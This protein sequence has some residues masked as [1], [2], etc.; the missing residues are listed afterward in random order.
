MM[1][2][3]KSILKVTAFYLLVNLLTTLVLPSIVHAS[4]Y[5]SQQSMDATPNPSEW[6]DL[7]TGDFHYDVP[8]LDVPG[9]DGSYRASLTYRSG[10]AADQE[11]SWVGLGWDFSPGA[12]DRAVNGFPDD[13]DGKEVVATDTWTGATTELY[14]YTV[15]IS[16]YFTSAD[17][18][19][20]DRVRTGS[21]QKISYS[22]VVL[23]GTNATG[24]K[25]YG[26]LN[27]KN[28]TAGTNITTGRAM[29]V[30]LFSDMRLRDFFYTPIIYQGNPEK[31]LGGAVPA[32]D[33]YKISGPGLS[34]HITPVVLENGSLFGSAQPNQDYSIFKSFTKTKQQFRFKNEPSNSFVVTP[35]N[36][37][38]V[39]DTHVL[40]FGTNNL[41]YSFR[42][43][44]DM[45]YNPTTMRL[46]GAKHI[47][48]FTNAEISASTAKNEGFINYPGEVNRGSISYTTYQQTPN[49]YTFNVT[50]Q[51]G[52]FSVTKEDGVTYHYALPAYRYG[53]WI[54]L[55]TTDKLTGRTNRLVKK[56]HAAAYTWLLT[57]V[58]GPDFV[59]KNNNGIADEEDA[60]SWTNY[61]YGRWTADRIQR[62]PYTGT[63]KAS[64]NADQYAAFYE[65]IYYLDAAYTRSHTALFLKEQRTDCRSANDRAA[66]GMGAYSQYDLDLKSVNLYR[67]E[68]ILT[69]SS[70]STNNFTRSIFNSIQELK[71]ISTQKSIKGNQYNRVIDFNDVYT[72]SGT[73]SHFTAHNLL[74][75]TALE[76]DYSLA[77][78]T[79]TSS[80]SGSGRL[81]L[82]SV[83]YYGRM[84]TR[85][86][87]SVDFEYELPT[88]KTYSA[89]ITH[90]PSDFGTTRDGR[91]DMGSNPN[92]FKEGD[93]LRMVIS[94]VTFHVTLVRG[95]VYAPYGSHVSLYD[96]HFLGNNIPG[97][98]K[99]NI[100]TLAYET[101]NPPYRRGDRDNWDYF[102]SDYKFTSADPGYNNVPVNIENADR[103]TTRISAQS[104]DVWSLRRIV[105]SGGATIDVEYESDAHSN[106]L[107]NY[108]ASKIRPKS[109]LNVSTVGYTK[110]NGTN[111]FSAP[112]DKFDYNS[113]A[114]NGLMEL[115]FK[116]W[117]DDEDQL[118]VNQVV[119]LQTLYT[120]TAFNGEANADIPHS[121][122][123]TGRFKISSV[124]KNSAGKHV[125]RGVFLTDA[126]SWKRYS[127]SSQWFAHNGS[128]IIYEPKQKYGGGLR[129]KKIMV[130]EST[131]GD[132]FETHYSYNNKATGFSSGVTASEPLN[133]G[134]VAAPNTAVGT[135]YVDI[136]SPYLPNSSTPNPYYQCYVCGNRFRFA[137]ES[138][139][140][141]NT[142]T[143]FHNVLSFGYYNPQIIYA[144]VTKKNYGN[145]IQSP[146]YDEYTFQTF[147]D[148]ML[149]KNYLYNSYTLN[150]SLGYYYTS[151]NSTIKIVEN[152]AKLGNLLY[153]N[154]RDL[155][156]DLLKEEEYEYTDGQSY[157]S[158]GQGLIE[159]VFHQNK[160]GT[161]GLGTVTVKSSLPSFLQKVYTRDHTKGTNQSVSFD[162]YDFYSGQPLRVST[163]DT[164]GNMVSKVNHPAYHLYSSTTGAGM[165]LRVVNNNNRNILTPNAAEYL[166]SSAG[167]SVE[168]PITITPIASATMSSLQKYR[169]VLNG[170]VKL[171]GRFVP[172]T[173]VSIYYGGT[174]S[175]IR[176]ITTIAPD[177]NSFEFLSGG[178]AL[179]GTGMIYMSTNGAPRSAS[180]QPWSNH[181][182]ERI[183]STTNAYYMNQDVTESSPVNYYQYA[184]VWKP[185][186]AYLWN[187]PHLDTE[188]S[189]K[190]TGTGAYQEF[191]W[192]VQL[193][194]GTQSHASWQKQAQPTLKDLYSNVLET[195]DV[196]GNYSAT[197]LAYN[198]N[199][200]MTLGSGYTFPNGIYNNNVLSAVK[201]SNA[202]SFSFT[203]FEDWY[204]TPTGLMQFAGEFMGTPYAQFKQTS[205]IKPHTGEYM[206]KLTAGQ[207]GPKF[208]ACHITTDVE[209]KLI[210]GKKY[211]A[212]VWVHKNS[213]PNAELKVEV[214]GNSATYI[215]NANVLK[216]SATV[217]SGDW[218]LMTLD[219][220]IPSNYVTINSGDRVSVYVSNPSGAID[221]YFD[222]LA[223]RPID[224]QM[225]SYVYD[226][227]TNWLTYKIDNDNFYTRF[228]YDNTGRVIAIYKETLQGE[229]KISSNEYN[230]SKP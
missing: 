105:T 53:E 172:N 174:S 201:N 156:G 130:R 166:Y 12:I 146:S 102:K 101:K 194:G 80:A 73:I 4:S 230:F 32:Y 68:D 213:D 140:V 39:A 15:P 13:Y 22:N 161:P 218:S 26:I 154:V 153:H 150:P 66:G 193:A 91:I 116:E 51:V 30:N 38:I 181:A 127:F 54:N 50:N 129:T 123:L 191:D 55:S 31:M 67:N 113:M 205:T 228:E 220:D 151:G 17:G 52:G 97:V 24:I 43:P 115:T 118:Y 29:D 143:G 209:G 135:D 23:P 72:T 10:I 121:G 202:V 57:T 221:S 208:V 207:I 56:D 77:P 74:K 25:Y 145:G 98:D 190:S 126:E 122:F 170:G 1:P 131:N 149:Q 78:Q 155:N 187:S 103:R 200:Y 75:R 63:A 89:F 119:Q 198:H 58:T 195:K 163:T 183:Y 112:V 19:G 61:N 158:S 82:K 20:Y 180:I 49:N 33:D 87:P 107:D 175:V 70:T 111:T 134:G 219:F 93:I 28:A 6:V 137:N 88:P 3:N 132:Y 215:A 27:A 36:M 223:I 138:Y 224:A 34:G 8:L 42:G 45:G 86:K 40:S 229:K 125:V 206:L 188:G 59:D 79:E 133:F 46:A 11:A 128:Y 185:V 94:G 168:V 120:R 144:Q 83:K 92:P 35:T 225:E 216:S 44:D 160:T 110:T 197:K 165:G 65:E 177:R 18:R 41:G 60:G 96:V 179:P 16:Q 136:T 162:T 90:V 2:R 211:R 192:S 204:R 106:L 108:A 21:F 227:I 9:P 182:Q 76:Y 196:N 184:K 186:A 5:T 104:V 99:K 222:D 176:S 109:V 199:H 117:L 178:T 173:S 69:M 147:S 7:K 14:S 212:S 210:R 71:N 64:D 84:E 47:N 95:I 189:Y 167:S 152:T 100:S 142:T 139:K 226:P 85:E 159:E 124:T 203:G 81:T 171:T 37:S 48:Y 141:Y 164:Y 157:G 62:V 114:T 148:D 169:A 217:F 214:T